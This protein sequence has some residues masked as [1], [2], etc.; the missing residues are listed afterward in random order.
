MDDVQYQYG[1]QLR[2]TILFFIILACAGTYLL[3]TGYHNVD[4]LIIE[5]VLE[6]S[7]KHATIF[8]Y[9][10]GSGALLGALFFLCNIIFI[11]KGETR[12]LVIQGHSMSIPKTLLQSEKTIQFN[13]IVKTRMIGGNGTIDAVFI[14]KVDKVKLFSRYFE[15]EEDFQDAIDL[16]FSKL[17]EDVH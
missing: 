5:R 10:F 11:I 12:Y 16:I 17:P 15:S 6:L 1:P 7:P 8:Y 13:D 4:G 2:I 3:W 14:T 9:V